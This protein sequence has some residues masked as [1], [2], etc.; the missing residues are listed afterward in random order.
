MNGFNAEYI[1]EPALMFNGGEAKD[2]RVGLVEY[3]PRTPSGASDHQ[4]INV[5][6][7]GS[8]WSIAGMDS[9][10]QNMQTAITAD[11]EDAKRWKPPF[12]GAGK[13][14]PLNFSISTQKRWRM[15]ITSEEIR[16]IKQFRNNKERMEH[17]LEIIELDMEVLYNKE[18]PPD[19]IAV[20]IPEELM[21]S[22]TPAHQD[23]AKIQS[24][25]SDF[26]N[27]IKLMG[28]RLGIPTQLVE[29]ATLRGEKQ[30][31][32][33]IAWNLAVGMLYKAQ[34]G[35][36]WKLAHLE[37]GTCYAG[38]SF[39]RE[40]GRDQSRTRAAMAQVFLETGES[41]I[42]RGDP[43][44]E[45][46]EGRGANHLS[47][48]DAEK[49]VEKILTHYERH[50]GTSPERLVLHKTSNFW[51]E[52]KEGFLNGAK[53]IRRKDFVTIREN[54]DIRVL[55]S[56]IYPVLRGTLITPPAQEE[57]YLYTK[58]FVP[59]L[60]TYP[61]PNIPEPLIVKPDNEISDTSYQEICEEILAFTKLDWN[62]SDFSKK[63]PVTI[64]VSRAVS[65]ILAEASAREMD[66]DS[67]Y[68][69]Y[70]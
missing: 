34:R 53:G 67:H 69:F 20:A 10:F 23:H 17:A 49:L 63:K 59:S 33:E 16:D 2:P 28:M 29:P 42:L 26:H 65:N 60:A 36:P 40:R 62:T 70:M 21:E 38:I 3:G 47:S 6:L 41:F 44:E 4:V 5:G 51:E 7:I 11:E 50:K 37:E 1:D 57:H 66:I 54:H 43:L 58:G 25:E 22:L 55:S 56:G 15:T 12:P 27:R 13:N 14:S 64:R 68:Y 45:Q 35:H 31:R 24:E 61:G 32:S 39:Y 46:A 18:T 19:V 9:L 52:E 8:S 30:G 48:I